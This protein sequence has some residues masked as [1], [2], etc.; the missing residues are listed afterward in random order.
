MSLY[1]TGLGMTQK[2]GGFD[3]TILQPSVSLGGADCP[4]TF[5]GAAPGFA[6]LDQIN[7]R[8]PAGLGTQSAAPVVV[9]SG[10]RSSPVTTVALE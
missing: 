1:L 6:G 2:R 4:V 5:A 3:Y 7:C 10:I 8:V 9:R